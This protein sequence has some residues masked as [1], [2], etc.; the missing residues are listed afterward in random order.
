MM[1]AKR[2]TFCPPVLTLMVLCSVPAFSARAAMD[3]SAGANDIG[4]G[5]NV[6]G[7][8]SDK[9]YYNLGGGTVLSQPPGRSN[10]QR[11]GMSMGWNSELMCGNFDIKT[12]VG[13]QL[14]G[15]TAGFKNL[16]SEVIQNAT[17]AVASLPAMAI[18]RANPGLYEM[19]TNG[20]LQ[21][22]VAFDKAQLSC[23]NMARRMMDFSENNQWTQAA[24]LEEAG[25]IINSGDGDAV[26]TMNQ[27]EKKPD[28]KA[29]VSWIGG[30][31][32]GGMGQPAIQPTQDFAQAGFNI[33]NGLPATSTASVPASQ[34]TGAACRR[35]TNSEE[36]AQVVTQVLG[37]KSVRTC[38]NPAD[39]Q[40]GG[41]ANQP[42]SSRPGTG[43][44]PVLETTTRE[45]LEQLHKLVNSRGVVSAADLAKLK[46]GSLT[47]S[48]GVIEALRR[49]PDK[50]ALTQ[51]LAGELAMADTMELALT[52]RRML[53]TGQGE[54]NAGN[55]PKAQEIGNQSVDQLDREIG[56][57]QTEMA[58]R[59]SIANNAMLT[60]IERDQQRT[61]A[62]PATQTPD[63]TDV[64]VQGLEQNSDTG[65][66]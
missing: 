8:V 50:T 60:V 18:Q 15:V 29:G 7:A 66:R 61:Q 56:M 4:Y 62:N 47:V 57:L 32:R 49:D 44:A 51:R 42:G 40:S 65:G 43:L 39:C 48:R 22:N 33:M 25:N 28:G 6:S 14:N 34:C 36:A 2:H 27:V 5:A 3:F 31:Q 10:L 53:I 58:V 37:S 46:T 13:N 59:K 11:L 35:F 54:P 1:K 9:L 23:Q 17:G 20:V 55:F 19:L 16:M 63:N 12:T 64:R 26:G 21:A 52:M 45:N 30:K 24:I 38:T 41:E